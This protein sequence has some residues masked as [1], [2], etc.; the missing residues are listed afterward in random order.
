MTSRYRVTFAIG[1]GLQ[2]VAEIN[3]A[4]LAYAIDVARRR[5]AALHPHLSRWLVFEKAEPIA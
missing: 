3:E 4:C 5:I 2:V 1:T